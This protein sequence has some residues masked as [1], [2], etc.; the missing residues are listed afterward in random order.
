MPALPHT[1]STERAAEE[2]GRRGRHSPVLQ[3]QQ[4]YGLKLERHQTT[5]TRRPSVKPGPIRLGVRRNPILIITEEA[6]TLIGTLTSQAHLPDQGGL[7]IGIDSVHHSLS[8]ALA[9]TPQNTETVIASRGARVFLPI[10]VAQ[11]LDERT[12]RAEITD[13]RSTFFLDQ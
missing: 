8:M 3:I 5:A 7:R 12:L 9:H 2:S 13:A 4:A 10:P 1:I 11:R 6:A